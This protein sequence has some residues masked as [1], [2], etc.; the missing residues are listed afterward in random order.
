MPRLVPARFLA[1]LRPDDSVPFDLPSSVGRET[2]RRVRVAALL[3]ALAYGTFLALL[4]GPLTA[5]TRLERSIDVAHDVAGL[6]ISVL[7]LGVAIARPIPDRLAIRIALA[8]QLLLVALISVAVTWAGFLRTGHVS[9]LTW[10]VPII[11][12]FP[13]LVPAAPRTTLLVSVLCGLTV[14]GSLWL[15]AARGS[16]AVAPS[17]YWRAFSTA[18]VAVAI[19]T[20][21]ARAVRGAHQQ[22]AAARTVGSYELE[23]RLELGGMGEVWKARHLL[24]ARPAAVKLILPETLQGPMEERDAVVKRF[25]REAQVTA[26]LRSPH[27]VELFDFGVAADGTF[28]YAMELLEGMNLEHF[29]YRFGALE[30]R[31][32]VHWLQQAC[33]SLGEA[34]ARALVHRD[35]KPGNLFI[36]RY[37]RD[38]DFVKVLDFGLTRGAAAPGATLTTPGT[39][40]G[41]PGYMPPEQVY[42]L[43][44]DQRTDLYALGCVGYWLLAGEK[45]FES[46]NAGELLRQHAQAAPPPLSSKAR[47]AVPAAIEAVVMACL[48]KDPERRPQSADQLCEA[49]DAAVDG[50]AWSA[51]EADRWWEENLTR[52]PGRSEFATEPAAR[53]E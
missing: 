1:A 22:V 17:D 50:N 31:R 28:Y 46:D 20:I 23:E 49:L 8:A 3:G 42:G 51:G 37:G 10:V 6:A 11:I 4:L 36:C 30:P 40:M 39:Q 15:L 53:K 19:A 25:L 34:H 26:S 38:A 21:A 48:S 18:G 16:I 9:T 52:G 5:V 2:R 44:I 24:L 33:H 35:I 41:T 29:V 12:L 13:L 43:P 7:L 47:Q 27:T 14:P 32:A 45:P